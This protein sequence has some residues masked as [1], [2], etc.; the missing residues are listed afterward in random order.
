VKGIVA[1]LAMAVLVMACD[2]SQVSNA[3]RGAAIEEGKVLYDRYGC[4]VCHGV[5]GRG[6]GPVGKLMEPRPR[7]FRDVEAF[8]NGKSLVAISETIENGV[9]NRGVGMPGYPHLP[10]EERRAI[11]EYVASLRES[12]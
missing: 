9:M 3:T 10:E 12:D 4:A 2:D 6:D 1:P 8:K 7:D 11:A 5:S